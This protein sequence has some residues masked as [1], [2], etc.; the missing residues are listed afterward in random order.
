MDTALSLLGLM[1]TAS[2]QGATPQ[3][4]A[5]LLPVLLGL[6]LVRGL[7]LEQLQVW[8]P[9]LL[10]PLPGRG[11]AGLPGWAQARQEAPVRPTHCMYRRGLS[12]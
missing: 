2:G 10:S 7:V 6:Q 1:I 9:R 8:G 3:L 11:A 5:P 4:L 12:R